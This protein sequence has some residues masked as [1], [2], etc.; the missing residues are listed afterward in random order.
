M[1]LNRI[2]ICHSPIAIVIVK[3][4]DFKL[5]TLFNNNLNFL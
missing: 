4:F 5:F 3:S 2:P 1:K